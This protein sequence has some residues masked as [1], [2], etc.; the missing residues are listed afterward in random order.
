MNDT[1]AFWRDKLRQALGETAMLKL[2]RKAALFVT[3][4]ETPVPGFVQERRSS[5][6]YAL[7]PITGYPPET[8]RIYLALLKQTAHK[9]SQFPALVRAARGRMAVCLRTHE[10]D[11]GLA[12]L[13]ALIRQIEEEGPL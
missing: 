7:S 4:C 5:G 9:D 2:D 11:G 6:L 1:L 8:Q 12:V 13:E 10:H 3:R